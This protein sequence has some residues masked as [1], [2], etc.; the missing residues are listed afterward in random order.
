MDP[1]SDQ[2][3]GSS[4]VYFVGSQGLQEPFSFLIC[5]LSQGS[6]LPDNNIDGV[7]SLL[8]M[9]GNFILVNLVLHLPPVLCHT[10][11]QCPAG[12]TNLDS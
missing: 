4:S 3:Q 9:H 12:L 5:P 8:E 6:L 1:E 11:F 2:H 7:C 10:D